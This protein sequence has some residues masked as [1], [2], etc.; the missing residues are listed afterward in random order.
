MIDLEEEVDTKA[1][2][3]KSI[4]QGKVE[5]DVQLPPR[6][7]QQLAHP[8]D[9]MELGDSFFE[10]EISQTKR[11]CIA[12]T[13]KTW[14]RRNAPKHRVASRMR[15]AEEE[16]GVPGVRFWKVKKEQWRK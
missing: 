11:Q 13:G 3:K 4:Y 12:A 2:Y 8:W 16:N 9:D 7:R 10:P 14:C 1:Y 15:T 5:K 6:K